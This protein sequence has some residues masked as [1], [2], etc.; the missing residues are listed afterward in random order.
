MNDEWRDVTTSIPA[1]Q[2]SGHMHNI[3]PQI[4]SIHPIVALMVNA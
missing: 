2:L 4:S 1:N 3:P